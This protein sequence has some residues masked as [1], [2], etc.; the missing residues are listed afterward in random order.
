MA[1]R[2]VTLRSECHDRVARMWIANYPRVPS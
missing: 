2:F 1:I